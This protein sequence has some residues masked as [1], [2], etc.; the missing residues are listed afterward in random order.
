MS[1]LNLF[2]KNWTDLVFE[3]RNQ[4][5][6]AYQLRKENEKTTLM[7]FFAALGLFA[8]IGGLIA[9]AQSGKPPIE[10]KAPVIDKTITVY[11]ILPPTKTQEK[12][13]PIKKIIETK[14]VQNEPVTSMNLHQ[15]VVTAANQVETQLTTDNFSV[16]NSTGSENGTSVATTSTTTGSST[17][18]A[19]G[20][21]TGSGVDFSAIYATNTVD[22]APAFPGGME[23]FYK[24]VKDNFR[25][26]VLDGESGDKFRVIVGFVVEPDG[27]IS[28]IRALNRVDKKLETEAIRTLKAI[29][30]KW[31]P[32]KLKGVSVRTSY[33][34]PIVVSL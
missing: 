26:N 18:T 12:V 11:Q 3:G 25:P 1:Q 13:A 24:N 28:Q 32:G 19:S 27:T 15:A 30:T 7:A 33:Q 22:S 21:T 17:G 4:S 20:T 14:T 16:V 34:L 10:L 9:L 31:E 6:G 2:G 8:L 23:A 5:Y 29:R